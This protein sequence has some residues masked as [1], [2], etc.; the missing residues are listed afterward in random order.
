M[1]TVEC[2]YCGFEVDE[3]IEGYCEDEDYE[4]ECE[5]CGKI[6]GY[7]IQVSISSSSHELPCGGQD[8]EG[9]HNFK[10]IIGF[11]E[12]FFRG[13]VRCSHCGLEKVIGSE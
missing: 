1:V 3:E 2:P 10:P 12:E 7:T 13:K 9:T 4:A 8:G 6:F 5:A 11:P